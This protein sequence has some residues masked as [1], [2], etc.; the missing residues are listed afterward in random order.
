LAVLVVSVFIPGTGCASRGAYVFA[1]QNAQYQLSATNQ[2]A[3]ADHA[4][5]REEEQALR[6]A[7]LAELEQQG[8]ELVA[9]DKAE[10]TL[11]YWIDESWKRG[12]L[13]V[14]NREGTWAYPDSHFQGAPPYFD[15]PGFPYPYGQPEPGIQ[16]VIDVPYSTM[17]IR[18]KL[19]DQAGMRSGR[20]QTAWEGY[21]ESGDRVSAKR[22]PV[23]LRTLLQYF[24]RDFVGRAKLI[25]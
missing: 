17:G 11:T 5:P 13:V 9:P 2:I 16:H 24:G 6:Q 25:Q 18:L 22:E 21:I 4:H 10:Y 15:P 19:F 7:L 3:I 14:S 20:M 12:K 8:F 1:R 23:L